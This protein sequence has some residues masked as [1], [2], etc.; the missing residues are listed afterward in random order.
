MGVILVSCYVCVE[1]GCI[2][3]IG[4][5][6]KSPK[7]T[8]M[9]ILYTYFIKMVNNCW[10]YDNKNRDRETNK[11]GQ[12]LLNRDIK[13]SKPYKKEAVYNKIIC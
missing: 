8:F 6:A 5:Y 13:N 4:F 12:R 7:M 10:C 9:T 3:T 11:A 2:E 1:K